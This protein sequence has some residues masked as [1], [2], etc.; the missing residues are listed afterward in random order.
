MKL[1][2]AMQNNES[3]RGLIAFKNNKK[4]ITPKNAAGYESMNGKFQSE[5][6]LSTERVK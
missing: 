6:M 1:A 5:S 4:E 2:V 3:R